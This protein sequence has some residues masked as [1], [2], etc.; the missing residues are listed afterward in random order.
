LL[1][2]SNVKKRAELEALLA[3]HGF[4]LLVPADVGGLAHVEEDQPTFVA[5]A[6]KKAAAAARERRLWSLAD[7]S[8]LEVAHLGGAPGVRSARYAGE[9]ADDEANRAKLLAALAEVP[10]ESRAARFVCAL[11]LARPD[12]SIAATIEAS[13]HGRILAAP[14]GERGFG[15]DPLFLFTEAG[16]AETGKAFAELSPEEKAAVSHRGRALRELVRR[17]PSIVREPMRRV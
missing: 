2:S 9:R 3:P 4:E 15:Y 13:A 14:R 7:D 1:A 11:A 6:C 17:L 10:S 5:N 12:G 8:G 16:C